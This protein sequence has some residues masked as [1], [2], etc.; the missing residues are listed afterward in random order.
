MGEGEEP[1]SRGNWGNQCEFFLSCLGFAVGFGNVWRF[2]YLC[3]R[4]GGAVFL[5]PYAIM[6]LLTG[7]PLFFMELAL[8]QYSSLGPNALFP[9]L[10][11][12]TGG[13][14]IGMMVCTALVS[15][16]YNMVF[17]WSLFYAYFSFRSTLLWSSC[18]NDY[19]T[20]GCYTFDENA[21]CRNQSLYYYNKECHNATSF[22]GI[23]SLPAVN[24]THCLLANQ[25][26]RAEVAVSRVSAAEDF[27]R[28]RMLGINDRTWSDMGGI[29]WELVACLA[30]AWIIICGCLIKG[31]KSS[32]KVVY[33][34]AIFPYVV[35]VILFVRGITLPGAMKGIEFYIMR[36]NITKL[37]EVQVWNDAA[38]QIFFSLSTAF[39]GLI[40][41]ASYNNF[42]V[43]CMRDSIVICFS[44]CL[45]SVFAGFVIFSILGF[46]AESA[47][48]E[49]KDVVKSGSGLAFVAYP[50]AVT[51]MPLPPLW[52]CL[53]FFMFITLGLDSQFAYV[54]TLTTGLFD[55]W[56]ALRARKSL[57]VVTMCSVMFLCGLTFCLDGGAYMFE[58]FNSFS[59]W[60]S[61]IVFA[62]V[63]VV[64]VSY[65]YGFKRFMKNIQEEMGVY[66]PK[67]MYAY[68]ASTWL[69]LSPL[70][71]TMV[72]VM[73]I[74]FYKPAYYAD[75][76]YPP[77]VQGLG[78]LLVLVS[79]LCVPGY[80]LYQAFY[81]KKSWKELRGPTE[82]FKPAHILRLAPV[83]PVVRYTYDN[84]AYQHK[85]EVQ[86]NGVDRQGRYQ[87]KETSRF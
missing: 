29:R 43:N 87:V 30:T 19:N 41:L 50:A 6:L 69:V 20:E 31:I 7:L 51:K 27:Y 80:A 8:G 72:F 59:G 55:Q 67:F 86:A 57:V 44:N 22:C 66:I 63:E 71:L 1:K 54:E 25:S 65:L 77:A 17:A 83:E 28:S 18:D 68:W 85:T 4:N 53:F 84:E 34:S 64:T 82:D 11:P 47:G 45:T 52:S 9:R 33:F 81:L 5:I 24:A 35:L 49:V 10:S 61:V 74:A 79:L 46:M 73:S 13:V 56:P 2:P 12:L 62:I 60:L 75:Y 23:D 36:P 21:L 70:V 48:V 42:K 40:T 14:G 58:L 32:G 39:G 37:Y 3:F 26:V 15:I 38:A 16:F 78:W 76:E